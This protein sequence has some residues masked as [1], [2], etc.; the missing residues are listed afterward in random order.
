MDYYLGHLSASHG[1]AYVVS[2]AEQIIEYDTYRTL[3]VPDYCDIS[4]REPSGDLATAVI[5]DPSRPDDG[6][7]TRG[8][9][10]MQSYCATYFQNKKNLLP[11]PGSPTINW[12]SEILFSTY[13]PLQVKLVDIKYETSFIRESDS[14]TSVF[15]QEKLEIG[16]DLPISSQININHSKSFIENFTFFE[17]DFNWI[18]VE[19]VSVAFTMPFTHSERLQ[20]ISVREKDNTI[21]FVTQDSYSTSGVVTINAQATFEIC[22]VA[23]ILEQVEIPFLANLIFESDRVPGTHIQHMLNIWGRTTGTIDENDRVVV[24]I[25]GKLKGRF[26]LNKALYMDPIDW[27][28]FSTLCAKHKRVQ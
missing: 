12:E 17:D 26:V 5:V 7:V 4:W 22:S 8:E 9:A 24:G 3:T 15:G 11:T 21:S 23:Y 16:Q 6:Y 28:N 10:G 20:T 27:V 13:P 2:E 25:T 19:K 14:V 18:G 1:K